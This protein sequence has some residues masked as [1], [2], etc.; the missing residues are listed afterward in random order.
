MCGGQDDLT[1]SQIILLKNSTSKKKT[2][3]EK[4]TFSM[5]CVDIY[6]WE[7]KERLWMWMCGGLDIFVLSKAHS[8]RM[9]VLDK[10][11]ENCMFF[12]W[13]ELKTLCL[14]RHRWVTLNVWRKCM[15]WTI[16]V[17]FVCIFV[18]KELKLVC[19]VVTSQI[20]VWRKCMF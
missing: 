19:W 10:N 7:K 14:W 9:Y 6:Y 16:C 15:F 20:G 1:I 11:V 8:D 3:T 13:K 2:V 18:R 4:S 5:I 12:V 17:G